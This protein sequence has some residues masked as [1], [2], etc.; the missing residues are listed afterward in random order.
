MHAPTKEKDE[1]TK[2]DFYSHLYETLYESLP[3][4]NV[5]MLLWAF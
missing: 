2:E 3:H 5:K 1:R 4:N